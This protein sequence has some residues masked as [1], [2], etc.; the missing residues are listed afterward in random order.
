MNQGFPKLVVAACVGFSALAAGLSERKSSCCTSIL[1]TNAA[2]GDASSLFVQEGGTVLSQGGRF[3]GSR[4]HQRNHYATLRAYREAI[5]EQW[6][7]TVQ[8]LAEDK[9]LALGTI[10]RENGWISTKSSEIPDTPIDVRLHDGTRAVGSVK[11]RRPEIDLALI[12]IDRER[13]PAITWSTE[14][15]VPLGGWL[16][17]ADSRSLPLALGV[18]SVL[19]RTVRQERSVLGIQMSGQRDTAYVE[20]V[21]VGSGAEKAGVREGDVIVEIDDNRLESRPE[22]LEYL[23][24]VPAGKRLNIVVDRDGSRIA[25]LAQMMDL[26][27]SLLDPTEMEVNGHISARSTGFRNVIQHDTV[28]APNDCGGPLIDVDGNCVGMNIARAGRICSY[29]LPASVVAS[30]VNEMLA[31]VSAPTATNVVDGAVFESGDGKLAQARGVPA[32]K[33][34]PASDNSNAIEV[35]AMKPALPPPAD[36]PLR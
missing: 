9:Q 23:G 4:S 12:K 14:T 21:V 8:I 6:K 24:T 20:N 5:G 7:S 33:V 10:V 36:L 27:S 15:A 34:V 28:L 3:S 13:L 32:S 25:M 30:T 18:V 16:A 11:I 29:A 31:T 19:S 2:V 26:S 1:E 17:S 22:V 35:G